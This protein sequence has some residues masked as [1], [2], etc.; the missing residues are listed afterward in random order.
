MLAEL[1]AAA[2]FDGG[3]GAVSF[4]GWRRSVSSEGHVAPARLR[5][6]FSSCVSFSARSRRSRMSLAP[7]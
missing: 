6:S 7:K 2:P 4:L 5:M 1:R 3:A